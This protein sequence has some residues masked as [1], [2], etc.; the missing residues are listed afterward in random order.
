MLEEH[1][2]LVTDNLAFA[3]F[4]A[5]RYEQGPYELDD[6]I[7]ISR[8]GLIKAASHFDPGNG[9][10]FNTFAG[11]CIT[12]EIMMHFRK[13]KRQPRCMSLDTTLHI[14]KQGNELKVE[15]IIADD[16]LVEDGIMADCDTAQL[17]A[18]MESVLDDLERH[19]IR[20]RYGLD[21]TREHKQC[22]VAELVG[23]SQS[24]VS[25]IEKKALGK[26][27]SHWKE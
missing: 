23:N 16:R 18:L 9:V 22:E 20:L 21:G 8:M 15:D 7:S 11:R 4:M 12:N 3:T 24:Y 26:L 1:E 17:K 2:R 5:L 14:D 25:R 6:L 13:A 19:V 27:R 10:K